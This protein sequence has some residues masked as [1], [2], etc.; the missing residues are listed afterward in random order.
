MWRSVVGAICAVSG[1]LG[2]ASGV[3]GVA[4]AGGTEA[5]VRVEEYVRV[6]DAGDPAAPV[7]DSNVAVTVSVR[8]GGYGVSPR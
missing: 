1:V 2:I 4:S 5:V 8:P 3:D 6:A 7:V